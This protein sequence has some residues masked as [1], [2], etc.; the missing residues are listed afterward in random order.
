M[1]NSLNCA[2]RV[3]KL[4]HMEQKEDMEANESDNENFTNFSISEILKPDF[5]R[6]HLTTGVLN[7]SRES[8]N[9]C[10]PREQ[11]DKYTFSWSTHPFHQFGLKFGVFSSPT[12][13]STKLS[14]I[15]LSSHTVSHQSKTY[16]LNLDVGNITDKQ[17][18]KTDT[19]TDRRRNSC[20]GSD[21]ESTKSSPATSPAGSP[22]SSP[23]SSN[24]SK[25]G[26]E[27]LWPAWVYCTRYSD[28]PSAGK[29]I[30][31]YS[32]IQ[33]IFA[34]SKSTLYSSI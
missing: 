2:N 4:P 12:C 20:S 27:K 17:N 15:P 33:L 13:A 32:V 3:F 25:A 23:E 19:K 6:K 8:T 7:L 22:G 18:E 28:R 34:Q 9:T 11:T 24:N 31:H 21:G 5:G 16:G 26:A 30:C 29:N 10:E 14:D 1:F